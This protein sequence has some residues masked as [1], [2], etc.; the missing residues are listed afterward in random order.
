[1]IHRG[2]EQLVARQAHNLEVA[3]SSPA[4]A[5]MKASRN[6]WLSCFVY[7]GCTK[8]HLLLHLRRRSINTFPCHLS[9]FCLCWHHKESDPKKSWE[10]STFSGNKAYP[11]PI[12]RLAKRLRRLPEQGSPI[13]ADAPT[14]S[15]SRSL[16]QK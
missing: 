5:T 1:M 11:H 6:D 13:P 8:K 7:Y 3:C 2:V 4:S 10:L 16:S 14:R 12:L 9:L 15:L